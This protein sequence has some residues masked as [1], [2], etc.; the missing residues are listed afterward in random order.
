[1]EPKA[2][3][4]GPK[5]ISKCKRVPKWSPWTRRAVHKVKRSPRRHKDHQKDP[6]RKNIDLS[7]QRQCSALGPGRT[8]SFDGG[9]CG[10]LRVF[11]TFGRRSGRDFD[12]KRANIIQHLSHIHISEPTRQAEISYAVF[13]LKKTTSYTPLRAR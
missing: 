8:N 1:M 5:G 4:S 6:L 7:C 2:T 3:N 10:Y 9:V 11:C 12:G 13:C